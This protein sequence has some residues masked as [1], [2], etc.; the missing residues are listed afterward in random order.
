MV[1]SMR[2]RWPILVLLCVLASLL[3]PG[4]AS[5]HAAEGAETRVGAFDFAEQVHVGGSAALTLELR[6]GCEPT[7]DH[8]A[9]DSLLVPKGGRTVLGKFPDYINLADDLGAKRF[10]IP[11]NVWARMTKAEQWIANRTFLDRMI[12]RGDNI[13]LSNPVMDISGVTGAFRQELDYLV[14]QG[15]RLSSD[16]TRMVR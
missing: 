12:S 13:I 8:L 6:P 10:N 2:S 4:I 3:V 16:G 14:E 15:F 9:S 5:A 11:S 7:Y 1:R